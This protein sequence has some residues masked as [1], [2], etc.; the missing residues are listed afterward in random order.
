[1]TKF[2]LH[3]GFFSTRNKL[4]R[5][6]LQE[7]TKSLKDG[8]TVLLVLFATKDEDIPKKFQQDREKLVETANTKDLNYILASKENFTDQ[9]RAANAIFIRGGE[10]SKL[11]ETVKHFPTFASEL[12]GKIVAGSSA[13][14]YLLSRFYHSATY[15]GVHEGLGILPTRIICHYQSTILPSPDD[16]IAEM[17]KYPQD[18]G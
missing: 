9:V 12:D 11:L 14:A 1:M 18:I 5:T 13:G 7:C 8:A 10:T 17:E 15:G 2:I 6:F 4:N 3:G 16:P